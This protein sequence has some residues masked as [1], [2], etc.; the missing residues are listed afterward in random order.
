MLKKR[1]TLPLLTLLLCFIFAVLMP[2]V[3]L[4]AAVTDFSGFTYAS[5][6]TAEYKVESTDGNA[7]VSG[8]T[9]SLDATGVNATSG[10][11]ATAA[12]ESTT[13]VT[14]TATE[15][16][17]VTCTPGSNVTATYPSEVTEN[18]DGSKTFT[19]QAGQKVSFAVKASNATKVSG[20]VTFGS[21]EPATS[22]V[23]ADCAAYSY[24]DKVY[25]YLDKVLTDAA[26]NG[27]GTIVVTGGGK[28]L[29]PLNFHHADAAG[30]DFV[31]VL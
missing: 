13:T 16:V 25:N 9:I 27:S 3:A 6:F 18:A 26:A 24:N 22:S 11:N 17:S 12:V 14:L 23:P 5:Y 28:A 29:H 19:V 31:D 20:E 10:C 30:A 7:S 8:A 21:V 4:A 1:H 2:V 15:T